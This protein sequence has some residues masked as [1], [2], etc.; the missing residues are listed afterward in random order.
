MPY[1]TVIIPTYNRRELLREALASVWAQTFT[2]YE[3]IVLDDGSTDGTWGE[4]QTLG[5]R[6]RAW[7]QHNA[8]PGPARNL[9][10]QHAI[11]EYLA[12]LDSDDLWFPW[13]LAC[14]A[15]LIRKH[16]FPAVLG[17]KLVEFSEEAELAWVCEETMLADVFADYFSSCRSGY[18]V[19]AGMSV[20]RR[21]EFLR[22]GGYTQRRINAEDHDLMLRL[23]NAR[24]FVQIKSPVTLGYRRHTGS[25]TKDIS[26][27]VK[28]NRY[29]IEQEQRGSY[30]GGAARAVERLA[31]VTRHVRPVSLECARQ[32]L[33]SEAW[34]LYRATLRWHVHLGRWKYLLGFPVKA[35]VS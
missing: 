21:E 24:G 19:G 17:A 15:E 32:G 28:G 26:M 13:T 22:I 35:L 11:G 6:V 29:L 33:R 2:D 8:G 7:R 1:F 12:F 20:V 14:F 3:V 27:S 30:P 9:G 16:D 31:I 18:Y 23:G 25:A 34:Q 4:L 10:A 5:S